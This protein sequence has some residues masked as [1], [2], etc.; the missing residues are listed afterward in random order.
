MI[1]GAA[2]V[3][4]AVVVAATLI[5]TGG[6][7]DD[8]SGTTSDQPA[9]FALP[10]SAAPIGDDTMVF[11]SNQNG[12]YDLFSG[13]VGPEGPLAD[14]KPIT[15]SAEDDLLPAISK[16]RR[17]VVYNH[18]GATNALFAVAADGSGEP[19]QLFTSGPAANLSI[20]DDARPSL[21]PDGKFLVVQSS[22]DDKG[23]SNTGLYVVRLDGSSVRRLNA[24]AQAT[25]P[26]WSPSGE[27]IAY[28]STR[29]EEEGDRGFIVVIPVQPGANPTPITRNDET[30]G[31]RDADPTFSPDGRR[32]AF[33]R[34]VNGDLEIFQMNNNGTN[35]EQVTAE[36]GA[37]QDPAF[38]PDG[39]LLTYSGERG[40]SV[41]RIFL[42]DPENTT[43]PDRP[44]TEAAGFHVRW[45]SG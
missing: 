25:D 33:S 31:E 19:V 28:W 24:A 18:R 8:D 26:A 14:V 5:A 20:V 34:E 11:A 4:A 23:D 38:S 17:T 12:N 6:G 7:D 40:G 16:D 13:R 37:D 39:S 44:L 30:K 41:R 35:L 1:I 22:T 3:V 45:S 32:I 27:R 15:T 9:A 29:P 2:A 21:S 43:A 36:A 10:Q 42:T